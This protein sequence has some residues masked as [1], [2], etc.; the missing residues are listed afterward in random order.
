MIH[1]CH[2]ICI[3]LPFS[4]L[5]NF[6]F[7]LTSVFSFI[8]FDFYFHRYCLKTF[9]NHFIRMLRMRTMPNCILYKHVDVN[10]SVSSRLL[11][12]PVMLQT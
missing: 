4:A 3:I 11:T 7:V 9:L 10:L 5:S 6:A 12:I 1:S 8:S 2:M